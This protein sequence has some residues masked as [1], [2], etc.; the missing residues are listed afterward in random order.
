M[1][2]D[3]VVVL[4]TGTAA[5][6]VYF[7]RLDNRNAL[8]G[9][10]GLPRVATYPARPRLTFGGGC[11]GAV[12]FAADIIVGTAGCTGTFA[13]IVLDADTPALFRRGAL[14]AL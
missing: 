9:T 13:A 7:R 8:L 4:D 12:R 2:G 3:V 6:L 11:L 10:H 14:E 1:R 5:T